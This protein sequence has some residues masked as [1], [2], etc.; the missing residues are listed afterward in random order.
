[1]EYNIK[2]MES[3]HIPQ[4]VKDRLEKQHATLNP[5]ELKRVI[6]QKLK[7]IFEFVTVTSKVRQRL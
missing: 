4:D 1:M 5:F 6:E 3:G 2:L 7:H